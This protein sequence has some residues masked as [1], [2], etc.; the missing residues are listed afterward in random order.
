MKNF[1]VILLLGAPSALH[2]MQP[3]Q[4]E[5]DREFNAAVL[6]TLMSDWD[7]RAALCKQL[8]SVPTRCAKKSIPILGITRLNAVRLT[9][10]E[11]DQGCLMACNRLAFEIHKASTK[12]FDMYEK[13]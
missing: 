13:D 12:K 6:K 7:R 10:F 1:I 11:E 9:D 8:C 2:A 3:T 4:T 5:T